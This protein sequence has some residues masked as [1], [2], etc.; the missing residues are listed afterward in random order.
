MVGAAGGV[1]WAS[2]SLVLGVRPE[3]DPV[4]KDHAE[5]DCVAGRH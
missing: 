3:L 4:E 5:Q 1:S 2:V